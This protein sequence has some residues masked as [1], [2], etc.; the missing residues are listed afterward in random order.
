MDKNI[1]HLGGASPFM[2]SF[3]EMIEDSF[4]PAEHEFIL[5]SGMTDA[6]IKD[7]ANVS[8]FNHKSFLAVF[9]YLRIALAISKSN[10]IMLHGLNDPRLTILLWLM[11]WVHSKLYWIIW[12]ADL[13]TKVIDEKTIKWKVM[14]F[15]RKPLI[16]RIGHLVTYISGD[17]ENARRWYGA[18]GKYHECLMY[19]S[20]TIDSELSLNLRAR[21]TP[22]EGVNILVGNSADP[23]NNHFEVLEKLKKYAKENICIYVPLSYGDTKYA[24]IVIEKGKEYFGEKFI[25]LTEFMAIDEYRDFLKSIDI[26]VFNHKKQQAM[27]NTISLLSMGKSVYIRS[28]VTQ[29]AFF[30]EKNIACLNVEYFSCR[31]ISS[32]QSS[33]NVTCC[34]SYFNSD[35][36]LRQYSEIF[37]HD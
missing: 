9:T 23:A 31:L 28:D 12:G 33:N 1:L 22:H 24:A 13:Y 18:T 8:I 26:A 4:N 35:N 37:Y 11:P 2:P 34:L 19:K 30:K 36:L 6:K 10:K 27:G 32:H 7:H 17:V 29:W 21:T 5:V 14:E 16:K 20:N 3:I 25:P 15:F